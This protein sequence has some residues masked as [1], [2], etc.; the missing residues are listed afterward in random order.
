M[1]KRNLGMEEVAEGINPDAYP[2]YYYLSIHCERRTILE[3]IFSRI[4]NV[5][6]KDGYTFR[7]AVGE[8]II[9]ALRYG[10]TVRVKLNCFKRRLIVRIKDDGSGFNGNR[11]IDDYHKKSKELFNTGICDEQGRGI[12][13]MLHWADRVIYNK[14]GNEVLLVK[15]LT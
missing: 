12:K 6:G 13:L 4:G 5:A 10:V 2:F 11:V 8:A 7:I 15:K 9:N 1:Q 14:Q 3:D